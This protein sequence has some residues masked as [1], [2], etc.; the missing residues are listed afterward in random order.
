M[1]DSNVYAVGLELSRNDTHVCL[2]VVI[3][4]QHFGLDDSRCLNQLVWRH[5]VRLITRQESNVDVLD[6]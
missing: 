5:H 2:T 1:S 3:R 4:E 6:G